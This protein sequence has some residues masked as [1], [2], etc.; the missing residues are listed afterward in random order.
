MYL[1]VS[2]TGTGAYI[3]SVTS[4]ASSVVSDTTWIAVGT[5][6]WG[7][8]NLNVGNAV[9]VVVN[10]SNNAVLEKY[11]Y[12][13]CNGG[14]TYQW[15]EAMQYVT[16]EG[17]QG[18]CPAGSHIPT[19]AEFKILEMFLGMSQVDADSVAGPTRGSAQGIGTSLMSGGASGLNLPLPGWRDTYGAGQQ[20]AW[21]DYLW[22]STGDG[23]NA[24]WRNVRSG[25]GGV[26]RSSIAVAFGYSV[27]CIAA[28]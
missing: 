21:E 18:I 15:G 17:A 25:N 1:K 20:Y 11:C 28:A 9:S 7:K 5:Q 10:Q 27:R 23:T 8:Y 22:T 4:A 6:I 14:G 3:G 2:A 19:D 16:T 24:I 26:G 12:V 13:D